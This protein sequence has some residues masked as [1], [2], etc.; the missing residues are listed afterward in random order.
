MIVEI[1]ENKNCHRYYTL[2]ISIQCRNASHYKWSAWLEYKHKKEQS[3]DIVRDYITD[4]LAY[5]SS[6]TK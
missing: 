6:K 4:S 5:A 1:K 3:M 2:Q